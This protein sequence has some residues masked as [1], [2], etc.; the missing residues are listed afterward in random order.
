MPTKL[1]E[2][3]GLS[4]EEEQM[5]SLNENLIEN[6]KNQ[7][8]VNEVVVSRLL[9]VELRVAQLEQMAFSDRLDELSRRNAALW[10][11][12]QQMYATGAPRP[13]AETGQTDGALT[14]CLCT[15]AQLHSPWFRHWL[16]RMGLEFRMHRKLWELCFIAQ[17][18]EERQMLIG[19][20]RGLGFAVGTE[21]LP[22]LFAS[23][24]CEILATDQDRAAAE[25]SG[26]ASSN[27]HAESLASLQRPTICSPEIFD[28]RVS[29]AN[30]DMNE[31][32]SELCR[33]EFDFVWSCC[34]FEHLGSIERGLQFV[35]KA[36]DCLKPGGVAVHSTE[37]N[38]SSDADTVDNTG[39][40]LY[41]RQDM[42]RLAD[43]LTARGHSIHLNFDTGN[44]FADHY[45]DLPPYK[46]DIHLRLQIAGYT[47]TSIALIVQKA[48]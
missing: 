39:T 5:E 3:K 48:S 11:A 12:F 42:Q 23:L 40:V 13:A 36:M 24:G 9:A 15:E 7:A 26:W 38:I 14:S 4:G 20:K 22:A 30:V 1:T 17:A 10:L 21:P 47:A 41:R 28:E 45:V 16:S 25:A 8:V 19:G 29:Y 35:L 32:S 33:G 37:F 18:L 43:E 34:S 31:I 44:G 6:V 46:Q 2:A 27:Q